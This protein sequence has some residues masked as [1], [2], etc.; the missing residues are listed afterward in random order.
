LTA[1]IK[2]HHFPGRELLAHAMTMHADWQAL[3]PLTWA[4]C[5]TLWPCTSTG[6]SSHLYCC[7]PEAWICCVFVDINT[8]NGETQ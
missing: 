2:W 5:A 1:V 6:E 3:A 4:R 8:G 7:E